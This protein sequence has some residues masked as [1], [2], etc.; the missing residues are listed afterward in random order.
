MVRLRD[1]RAP[2][3]PATGK[4]ASRSS[5]RQS[6][7]RSLLTVA[8]VGLARMVTFDPSALLLTLA[9]AVGIGALAGVYPSW[10]ASHVPPMEAIR[11]E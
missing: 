11:N 6:P 5:R 1:G 4:P 8:G 10:R 3:A 9:V 7:T 2:G